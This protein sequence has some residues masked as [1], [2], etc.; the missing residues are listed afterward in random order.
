MQKEEILKKAQNDMEDEREIQV[1]DKSFLWAYIIL[2]LSICLFRYIGTKNT[3]SIS[4]LSASICLSACA[5]FT[6]RFVKTKEKWYLLLAFITLSAAVLGIVR[7][8]MGH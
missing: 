7:F 2:T 3:N 8:F 4:D 6:Y 5:A 1:K